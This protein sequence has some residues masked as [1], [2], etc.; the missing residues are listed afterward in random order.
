MKM[1][2]IRLRFRLNWLIPID[3]KIL[4][5]VIPP[6]ETKLGAGRLDLRWTTLTSQVQ[7]FEKPAR[8]IR[9]ESA[10]NPR[11][12]CLDAAIG[13]QMLRRERVTDSAGRFSVPSLLGW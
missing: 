12:I 1:Y 4:S 11:L 10:C 3:P 8:L 6:F 7:F 2:W 9:G 13:A 5:K